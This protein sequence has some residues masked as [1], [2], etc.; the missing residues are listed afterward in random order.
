MLGLCSGEGSWLITG[1]W[2]KA[3]KLQFASYFQLSKNL[4]AHKQGEGAAVRKITVL[5]F[6]RGITQELL[7]QGQ[8]TGGIKTPSQGPSF[9]KTQ[10]VKNHQ[11]R[12]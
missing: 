11:G 4:D 6:S 9:P 3:G 8:K 1:L 12:I 5:N 7:H 2:H 10:L